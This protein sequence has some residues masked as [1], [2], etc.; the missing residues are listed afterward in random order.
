MRR[1]DR[2]F[3]L[4]RLLRVRGFA[5]G[6][7]LAGELGVSKRTVYRDIRDLERSGV[8]IRGEAGVGYRL[9]RGFELPPLTFNEAE[10]EALVLGARIVGAWAD[11]QLVEAAETALQRL[12]SVLPEPLRRVVAATALFAPDFHRR[13]ELVDQ[14]P[15]IRRAIGEHRRLRFGYTRADGAASARTVRPFGLYF[16]GKAWTLASWC[17]VRGD[18]RSFRPD[19]MTSL[20]MLDTTFDAADGPSL[21]GFLERTSERDDWV[22]PITTEPRVRTLARAP[23]SSKV[24]GGHA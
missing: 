23:S 12:E 17:E 8:P 3:Q 15:L 5:T 10:I 22:G 7:E 4:V 11:D 6:Q 16:W 19:R 13:P 14:L 24:V 9:E 1:A 2:L 18:Y 20:E 21:Q